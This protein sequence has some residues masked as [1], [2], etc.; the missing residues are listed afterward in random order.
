MT[1]SFDMQGDV[2]DTS[3]LTIDTRHR[4]MSPETLTAATEPSSVQVSLE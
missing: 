3:R 1:V 2:D 4:V